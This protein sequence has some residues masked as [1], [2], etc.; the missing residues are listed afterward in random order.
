MH[1]PGFD[2]AAQRTLRRQQALLPDHFVQGAR[3]HALGQR[4][5]VIPIDAQQIGAGEGS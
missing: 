2:R 1:A 3:A 5:Q 4:A